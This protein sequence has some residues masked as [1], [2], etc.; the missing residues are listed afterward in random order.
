MWIGR[1]FYIYQLCS[2]C[3]C[4]D[5][6]TSLHGKA[7]YPYPEAAWYSIQ[8]WHSVTRARVALTII[9]SSEAVDQDPELDKFRAEFISLGASVIV[10]RVTDPGCVLSSQV[11]CIQYARS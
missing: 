6:S 3:L 5:G 10:L 11:K 8:L 2:S 9:T 7:Q 4:W 1:V